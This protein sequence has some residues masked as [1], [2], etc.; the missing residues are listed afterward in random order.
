MLDQVFIIC[1]RRLLFIELRTRIVIWGPVT[2]KESLADI[3]NDLDGYLTGIENGLRKVGVSQA[4]DETSEY[5][6]STAF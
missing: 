3:G 4:D 1:C 6:I 2:L 5:S